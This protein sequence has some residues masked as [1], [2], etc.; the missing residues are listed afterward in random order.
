MG[1][2]TTKNLRG[3]SSPNFQLGKRGPRIR[4]GAADP[5]TLIFV[6]PQD[7]DLYLQFTTGN[8]RVW[9]L[10]GGTWLKI[11]AAGIPGGGGSGRWTVFG[12]VSNAGAGQTQSILMGAVGAD[13][14]LLMFRAGQVVG[15]TAV[16]T[17]PRTQGILEVQALIGGVAQTG[18]GEVLSIDGANPLLGSV[19]YTL[20]PLSPLAFA[21]NTIVSAQTITS[22]NPGGFKPTAA[23]VTVALLIEDAA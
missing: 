8:E 9:Q 19:D 1:A 16:L 3:T 13:A 11:L 17:S 5:N 21:A 10:V 12:G 18:P 22:P 15:M 20:P 14:G 4:K 2:R 6:D 7:G 23:S